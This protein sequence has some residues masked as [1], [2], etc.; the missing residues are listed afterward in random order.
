M[1]G[2]VVEINIGGVGVIGNGII[3]NNDGG[4]LKF[5][6][7]NNINLI[8]IVLVVKIDNVSIVKVLEIFNG[9][10]GNFLEV[11]KVI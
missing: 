1:L 8:G 3:V 4:V 6:E 2:E 5:L 9:N 10:L 7:I 11:L